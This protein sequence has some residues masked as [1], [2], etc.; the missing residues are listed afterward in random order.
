MHSALKKD[1]K[2]LYTYAREGIEVERAPRD[3]IV[4][5]LSLARTGAL[6]AIDSSPVSKG[7]YIRTL[8]EDIGEA[9]GCGAHLTAL[10]RLATG[11][12]EST[13]ASPSKRSRP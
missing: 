2:A 11:G 4:K 12:F 3:V 8:G 6:R 10:R 5:S 1:G 13:I 9:L 7:T